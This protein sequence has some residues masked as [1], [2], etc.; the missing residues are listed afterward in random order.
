MNK[1][2]NIFTST[3]FY[4]FPSTFSKYFSN[5]SQ[6]FEL[7]KLFRVAIKISLIREGLICDRSFKVPGWEIKQDNIV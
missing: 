7:R 1:V 4:S 6:A 5:S 3:V 2:I